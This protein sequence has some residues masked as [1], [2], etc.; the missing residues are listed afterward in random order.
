MG[1]SYRCCTFGRLVRLGR[2]GIQSFGNPASFSRFVDLGIIV[3]LLFEVLELSSYGCAS[4]RSI[5]VVGISTSL[6]FE[7]PGGSHLDSF[8]FHV[9]AI[10]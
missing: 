2:I 4:S 7:L 5:G 8:A 6:S 3:H 1:L 10:N 9:E